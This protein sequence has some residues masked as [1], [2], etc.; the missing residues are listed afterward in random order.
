VS[1]HVSG[2]VGE[3]PP[4]VGTAVLR[5][6]QESVTNALRYA[7]GA[8]RVSVVVTAEEDEVGIRVVDDGRGTGL[9]VGGGHGLTG[10]TERARLLGG[11]HPQFADG[12]VAHPIW[13]LERRNLGG[14]LLVAERQFAHVDAADLDAIREP[15]LSVFHFHWAG[16][17][18][19]VP[20]PWRLLP[21][22]PLLGEQVR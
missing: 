3:L 18:A 11:D 22:P 2:P 1:V 13:R 5:I 7:R 4:E 15:P 16:D 14:Q 6:A 19:P 10:M 9:S 20:A 17:T 12:D 8:T 21:V